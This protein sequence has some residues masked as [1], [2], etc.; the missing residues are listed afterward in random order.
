[1]VLILWTYREKTVSSIKHN[2]G[3]TSEKL[4]ILFYFLPLCTTAIHISNLASFR[5]DPPAHAAAL[6]I[7]KGQVPI[8]HQLFIPILKL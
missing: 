7:R 4:C 2:R 5:W 6:L 8:H 3:T 1:M